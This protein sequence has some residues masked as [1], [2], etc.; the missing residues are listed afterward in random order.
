MF[1]GNL[2]LTDSIGK[3]VIGIGNTE[4]VALTGYTIS[5][6]TDRIAFGKVEFSSLAAL[7]IHVGTN[8]IPPPLPLSAPLGH[9]VKSFQAITAEYKALIDVVQSFNP[10]CYIVM[11]AIIAYPVDHVL[12]WYWVQQVN[13][14]LQELCEP[15]LIFNPTYK[16]FCKVWPAPGAVLFPKGSFTSPRG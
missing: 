14:S 12:T 13:D 3:H 11:S 6:M 10:H 8:E 16:I 5:G 9:Q 1:P 4:V 15:C 7:L 2:V